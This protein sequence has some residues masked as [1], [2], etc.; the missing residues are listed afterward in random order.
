VL[1]VARSVLGDLDLDVVLERVVEAARDLTGARYAALGVLDPA[2]QRLERFITTGVDA[3]TREAIGA[4]PRGHG[5]LGELIRHPVPLRVADVGV[6]PRSYGFPVG[7]PAMKSFLGVPIL[8]GGQPYGNLYL[9]EKQGADEFDQEDED[10]IVVLA[11]FAGVAIDHARRYTG[12]ESRREELQRTVEALD[13]TLQITRALGGQT[14]LETILELVAKRGRALVSA[15][16]VVIEHRHGDA[17]VVAAGAGQLPRDLLGRRVDLDGSVA[18]EALRTLCTQRLEDEPN[19]TRFERHG[20][21]RLGFEARAGLVVPL[22][23]RG[24]AEGVLVAIDRLEGGPA[25]SPDDHRL[26]EAFA[27]SAAIAIA[28]AQSVAAER[29]SQRLAAAE[30]E[31]TRWARE[32]HDDTLQGLAS[33]R[34]GLAASLRRA[35]ADDALATAVRE[36]IG[37]LDAEIAGLRALITELRP[38]ALDQLGLAA[39]FEALANR[40]REGGLEVDVSIDLPH[41]LDPKLPRLLPELETAVY[42]IAQEALTNARKHGDA[43]RAV[44]EVRE[45]DHHVD[46]EVRDDG[47][48]FDVAARN[49]GGF[50]LVGMR[51]RVELLDGTLEIDSAVGG[52]TTIRAVFPARYQPDGRR[53]DLATADSTPG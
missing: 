14:D 5:V 24:R 10:A 19:R 42:R 11:D 29:R 21:G 34:L 12:S 1:D 36:A 7:H 25:F 15:R 41:D 13:A 50:G 51:E 44:V 38:A 20:L 16:T 52:G 47:R 45:Q 28:T 46:V 4:L 6:H 27:S 37:Q 31:R 3:A 48:G 9:T 33:V 35:G 40:A 30:Q 49:G 2:R 53:E 17:L 22:V 8:I 18:S 32:L 26:L 39:A 23:F 43:R